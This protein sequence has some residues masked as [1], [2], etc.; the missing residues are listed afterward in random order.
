MKHIVRLFCATLVAVLLA[1]CG[2]N[3]KADAPS[4]KKGA[5]GKP[6]GAGRGPLEFPVEVTPVADD[7]VEYIVNAVGSVEAF[8]QIAVTARV[9]GVVE[10]V[11]FREGE[12]VRPGQVLLEIEPERYR[13]AVEAAEANL[14]KEQA[15]LAEAQAGLE[16]RQAA[17]ERNPG[18]I[19]GEEVE[20]WRTRA[21]TAAAQVS[22]A[23]SQVQGAKLNL[24]DSFVRA[25]TTG[26]IQTRTVQTGQFVQPGTVLATLVRR[27]PL[28]LRFQV[29]EQ[30]APRLRKGMTAR[31]G[32][33]EATSEYAAAI[34][35]VAESANP[36]SRMVT[37][38]AQIN[39]PKRAELRPG[40]FAR[41]TVPVG[42]G[43]RAPV[44]PQ[45]AI[46]PSER[47]F[48]AFVVEGDVAKER[49]LELGLRTAEGMVEVRKGLAP[50]EKLV[51]RG[52]EAL[53]DGAKVKVTAAQG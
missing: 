43:R 10:H 23:R 37:V 33:A 28:L 11:R 47:G 2:G 30:E 16:R 46:R 27:D 42:G 9:S 1:A 39:D 32:V 14:A 50:G 41:V 49:I 29:P 34:T 53:T 38:T 15:S 4:G 22:Q 24:R 51:V 7:N 25:T 36:T 40:A 6:G 8:E 48:L 12:M 13:L 18:L 45:T 35:L 44:V 31:F 19:R 3:S 26:A 5:S 21:R 52:A 20:T 17:S